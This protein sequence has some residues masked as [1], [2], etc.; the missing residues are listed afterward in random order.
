MTRRD[1]QGEMKKQGR[2]WC[3][4]KG[5]DQSAPIGPIRPI[6]RTGRSDARA[7][8]RCEVNGELR[9]KGDLGQLI[10]SVDE[11]IE[12]LSARPGRCSPAT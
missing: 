5:F 2:P 8:S 6:A 9:Q 4:G 10:W 3:I 1:L 11:I 7:R 12:H